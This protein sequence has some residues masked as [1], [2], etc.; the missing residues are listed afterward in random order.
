MSYKDDTTLSVLY[1]SYYCGILVLIDFDQATTAWALKTIWQAKPST[2]FR[3]AIVPDAGH[4]SREP[5]TEKLLVEA[6]D[7][8]V[9]KY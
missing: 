7:E 6:A 9:A 4:S 5:E 1:V 2:S 8:V 3:I